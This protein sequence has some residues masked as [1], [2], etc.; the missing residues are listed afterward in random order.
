MRRLSCKGDGVLGQSSSSG[1]TIASVSTSTNSDENESYWSR[2][3]EH[4]AT[5]DVVALRRWR[6]RQAGECPWLH[7]EV[8]RRMAERLD[9]IRLQPK[10]WVNWCAVQGGLETHKNLQQRF[11]A[12]HAVL[13]EPL[14]LSAQVA[15]KA[16]RGRWWERWRGDGP[17]IR[18]EVEGDIEAD[19]VWANMALH[20]E[21]DAQRAM[22]QWLR[23]LRVGGMLMFSCLGPGTLASLRA[24]YQRAGWGAPMAALVDM[25]DWGDRL[26]RVGFSEPVVD[27]ETIR[28]SFSSP[29]TLLAE[30]RG[31]GANFSPARFAG[32]RGR[33]WR[34]GLHQGMAQDLAGRDGQNRLILEIEVVYGHAI[35]PE[36]RVALAAESSISLADF[37]R[38]VR[39]GRP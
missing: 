34:D 2:S 36:P 38:S 27:M 29:A 1:T 16:L 37:T 17:D 5:L 28:L 8:G 24:L 7:G 31:I 12:S 32:L 3:G 22:A 13:V 6:E 30:L 26:V 10:C 4:D 39:R 21:P 9:W 15:A 35:R 25:H 11:P 19:M 20:L 23:G 14:A 33:R 18:T